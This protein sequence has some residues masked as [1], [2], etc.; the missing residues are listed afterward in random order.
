VEQRVALEEKVWKS[1]AL[2]QARR[3]KVPYE[4]LRLLAKLKEEEIASW[5][6]RA[7]GLTCI[8]LRRRLEGDRER[9]MRA[10]RRIELSLPRRV[11]LVVAAAIRAIRESIGG[12]GTVGMCLAVMAKRFIDTWGKVAKRSR[13]RSR[14]IRERDG[15][16]C[17]VPGCSHPGT[18]THHIVFRSHGGGNEPEKLVAVCP[19]HHLRCI[20]GGWLRVFG[21]APDQLTWFLGG[22]IWRGPGQSP[23]ENQEA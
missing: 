8:E 19:F 1:P 13:S 23:A 2:Q 6:P 21:R 20:H 18:H 3:Q 5:I 7:K 4:K 15:G 9:Q 17:Q 22:K 11:A 16:L 14:K 12:R 10:S